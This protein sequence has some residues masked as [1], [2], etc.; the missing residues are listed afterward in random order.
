MKNEDADYTNTFI[1]LSEI[2]T[3]EKKIKFANINGLESWCNGWKER[4]SKNKQPITES[5][6]MMNI[7]NPQVIPRN[8]KVEAA[9]LSAEEGNFEQFYD[10][11]EILKNPY[12]IDEKAKPFQKP[13]T[14][15]EQVHET[16]C[17]T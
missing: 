11:L 4:L 2:L 12:K 3:D 1:K 15:D 17:G 7:C 13:P 8:H 9:L 5:I 10:L 14:P 16:F 6:S